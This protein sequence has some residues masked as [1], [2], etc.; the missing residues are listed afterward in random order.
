MNV[1]V[2]ILNW[3]GRGHLEACFNA[4]A[5]QT[6]RGF[7]AI[8]VDN[9]S[10]DDS[11]EYIRREFPWVRLVTLTERGLPISPLARNLLD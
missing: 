5:A 10:Q 8:M 1:S 6:L 7:E 4:L 2:I 3:N 11:V 9:A